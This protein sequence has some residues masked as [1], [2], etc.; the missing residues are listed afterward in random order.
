MWTFPQG[1]R[2]DEQAV[3]DPD[4]D[5]PGILFGSRR[6]SSKDLDGYEVSV[7]GVT[8][9]YKYAFP[10]VAIVYEPAGEFFYTWAQLKPYIKAGGL[11]SRFKR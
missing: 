4:A 11:L 8:F 9:H 10:H 7:K 1:S 3:E 5:D 6:F 2:L